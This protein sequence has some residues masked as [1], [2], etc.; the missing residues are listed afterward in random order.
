METADW[1]GVGVTLFG[2]LAS[3]AVTLWAVLSQIRGAIADSE[4]RVRRDTR[5]LIE[6]MGTEN[7]AAHTAIGENINRAER[8]LGGRI[9]VLD[10][11]D[12]RRARAAVDAILD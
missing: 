12:R 3:V 5:S 9:D 4:A 6:E 2:T 11:R 1:V 7:R 10:Q 8:E